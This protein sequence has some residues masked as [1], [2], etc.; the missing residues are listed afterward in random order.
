M[1]ILIDGKAVAARKMEELKQRVDALKAKGRMP[2][3]RVVQVGNDPASA[4]YIRQKRKACEAL[5]ID[6]FHNILQANITQEEL[7]QQLLEWQGNMDT[8]TSGLI[9]QL[10]LPN[11]LDTNAACETIW[12]DVDVDGLS[13]MSI[14]AIANGDMGGFI[15]CTAKGILALLKAYNVPLKGKHAVV[16]GRSNIVGKPVSML[17]LNED[18]TVTICHSKTGNLFSCTRQADILIVAAGRPHMIDCYAVKPGAAVIDVGINR[19]PDGTLCR[20]V[21][22][23]SVEPIAGWITPVPGGVG[24]MTVAMLMENVILAEERRATND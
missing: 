20:D 6:C 3:L 10:P 7:E 9:V 16:V 14:G 17:L 22:F 21:D 4:V 18:C 15:P 8:Y 19:R 24:P 13:S 5:G 12:P 1:A 11:G 23:D 2:S